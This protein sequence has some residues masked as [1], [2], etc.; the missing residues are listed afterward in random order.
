MRAVAETWL[1]HVPLD[2]MEI[3]RKNPTFVR[4]FTRLLTSNLD[5]LIRAFYELHNP[6]EEFRIASALERITSERNIVVP[7]SQEDIGTISHTSRKQVSVA[8]KR[9]EDAGWLKRGYRS[10]EITDRPR[11]QRFIR[12]RKRVA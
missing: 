6:D 8:L 9:F 2:A 4:C 12:P 7:L 1:A 3:A 11:L 10:I 5:T